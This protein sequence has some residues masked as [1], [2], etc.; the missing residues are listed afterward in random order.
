MLNF[1]FPVLAYLIGSIPFGVILTKFFGKGD[2]RKLGSGN[3]GATNVVR[4]QGKCLGAAVFIL[5]FLKGF[6][7]CKFFHCGNE[8]ANLA[9]LAAPVIGHMFP[10]WS[11]FRGGGKG[12]ATYFGVLAALNL[13]VFGAVIITWLVMFA[14][15]RVSAVAGLLSC[16]LSGFY[17]YYVRKAFCFDDGGVSAVLSILTALIYFRHKKNIRQLFIGSD[18]MKR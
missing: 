7:V 15:S 4:T 3:I 2:I 18:K 11:K 13:Y 9:L 10:A 14:I 6:L 12:V 8:F 16:A 17:F 1:I 5:D